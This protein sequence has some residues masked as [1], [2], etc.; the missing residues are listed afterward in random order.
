[1]FDSEEKV[2][3]SNLEVESLK[4]DFFE[5]K[6]LAAK[7]ERDKMDHPPWWPFLSSYQ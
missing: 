5:E 4:M 2:F 7:T 1:M 6:L 3:L